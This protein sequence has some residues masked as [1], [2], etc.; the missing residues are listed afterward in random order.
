M[1]TKTNRELFVRRKGVCC[2]S[3]QAFGGVAGE[4][5]SG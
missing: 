4:V 5:M 3:L 2:Q 1:K